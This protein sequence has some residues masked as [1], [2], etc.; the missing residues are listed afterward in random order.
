LMSAGSTCSHCNASYYNNKYNHNSS[1]TYIANGTNFTI[2]YGQGN[3]TGYLSSDILTLGT[4]SFRVTFGEATSVAY[5]V[6]GTGLLGLAYRTLSTEHVLP[7]F[8]VAWDKGYLDQ[9]LF[10]WYLQE[11]YNQ[12]G[13]LLLG[14]IDTNHYTGDIYYTPIVQK[15]W[16][17]VELAGGV[18]CKG[19]TYN[20]ATK[21]IIDSGTSY[22]VGPATDVDRIA[23][24]IGARLNSAGNYYFSKCENN[25]PDITFVVGNNT[26]NKKFIVTSASYVIQFNGTCWLAMSGSNFYDGVDLLWIMGDVF[27][28]QW[29]SIFDVGNRRMGFAQ[30][31]QPTTSSTTTTTYPTKSP[32]KHPTTMPTS[33]PTQLPTT[34]TQKAGNTKKT[35]YLSF[36]WNVYFFACI[37]AVALL[38]V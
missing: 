23:S 28:R 36:S 8:W 26:H 38:V 6:L 1:S 31:I 33:S 3:A 11:D 37:M 16:Y 2:Q 5:P 20:S 22:L 17:V 24:A 14:G 13:E 4:A 21:A 19:T 18:I 9:F 29:Y 32:T 15:E 30:A 10:S 35:G 27:M 12:D 7:P 25:L 34:T